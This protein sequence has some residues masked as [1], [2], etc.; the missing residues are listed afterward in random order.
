LRDAAIDPCHG[1]KLRYVN[2]ATGGPPMPTMA[3]FMQ[4]LPA[5]FT[6]AR[7]RS[8]EGTIYCVVEGKG[9]ARIGDAVFAFGPRDVFVVPSWHRLAVDADAECVPFS[10][11]DRRVHDAL[12]L[13]RGER[14]A[15]GA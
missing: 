11:A 12:G 15:A 1:T 6:G 5:R 10:F 8:T 3:S 14:A 13:L 7:H 2:P 4:L 9:R